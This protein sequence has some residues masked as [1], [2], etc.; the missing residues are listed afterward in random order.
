[1]ICEAA[2]EAKK[3]GSTLYNELLGIYRDIAFYK[4]RLISITKKGIEGSSEIQQM[5]SDLRSNPPKTVAGIEVELLRD[6]QS[7]EELNLNSQAIK[8]IEL[9]KSNVIQLV[10]KDGSII[11]ARP[12]GTEPKIKFYLSVKDDKL[13]SI[14]AYEASSSK[15]ESKMDAFVND[16]NL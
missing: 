9:P 15:L 13:S 14:E 5:M 1:M 10:L 3:A 8:G 4:E 11:T 2:A 16:L 7:Q 12:S 6:Y